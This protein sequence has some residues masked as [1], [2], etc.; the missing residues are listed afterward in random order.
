M[1][2]LKGWALEGSAIMK[3]FS[4]VDFKASIEFLNKIAEIAEKHNHHP[5]MII[6]YGNVRL[7]LTTHE[8]KGL[9][10]KDFELAKE[11][12]TL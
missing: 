10:E 6:N 2:E 7:I 9:T 8:K 5:E 11:I 1:S 3:E 4:F 12:D